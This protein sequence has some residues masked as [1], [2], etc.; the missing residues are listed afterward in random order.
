[1]LL[2]H[3]EYERLMQESSYQREKNKPGVQV[4]A[5][6]E[7]VSGEGEL[8]RAAKDSEECVEINAV[9]TVRVLGATWSEVP[10]TFT[11]TAPVAL[12]STSRWMLDDKEGCPRL[13]LYGPGTH[14]I[15]V[16]LLVPV[17]K[18]GGRSQLDF[19]PPEV[20]T[21]SLLIHLPG[22]QE[23]RGSLPV[24]TTYDQTN[25]YVRV[26]MGGSSA[27]HLE[28]IPS[29][30]GDDAKET[31]VFTQSHLAYAI[32]DGVIQITGSLGYSTLAGDLPEEVQFLIPPGGS[33]RRLEGASVRDWRIEDRQVTLVRGSG[34]R[35]SL[36]AEISLEVPFEPNAGVSQLPLLE[37]PGIT[38]HYGELALVGSPGLRLF[39]E[40]VENLEAI[41]TA[42]FFG[43]Q[44]DVTDRFIASYKFFSEPVSL[45]FQCLRDTRLMEAVV[46]TWAEFRKDAVHYERRIQVTQRGGETPRITL[47]LPVEEE[48]SSLI[49]GEGQQVDFEITQVSREQRILVEF[50]RP[51]TAGQHLTYVLQ[52]TLCPK[53]YHGLGTE[54]LAVL[55]ES[56]GIEEA[57][58]VSGTLAVGATDFLRLTDLEWR[59]MEPAPK[60]PQ[61]PSTLQS[62]SFRDQGE[63]LVRVSRRP[64]E[65]SALVLLSLLPKEGFLSVHGEVRYLL[66]GSGRKEFQLAFPKGLGPNFFPETERISERTMTQ[67]ETDDIWKLTLQNEVEGEFEV[68]FHGEIPMNGEVSVPEVWVPDARRERGYLI[69]EANAETEIDFESEGLSSLDPTGESFPRM[70]SYSPSHRLIAAFQYFVHP[71]SLKLKATRHT[72][73]PVLSAMADQLILTTVVTKDGLA[74]SQAVYSLRGVRVPFLS[75]NLP[76]DSELWTVRVGGVPVK[77]MR[78]EEGS[79]QIPLGDSLKR[80]MAERVGLVYETRMDPLGKAGSFDVLGPRLSGSVP[81][82]E[83]L[84]QLYLPEEYV[85]SVIS[86]DLTEQQ[87]SI[88]DPLILS[89]VQGGIEFF[90]KPFTSSFLAGRGD[91]RALSP[92]GTVETLGRV[93]YLE[94]GRRRVVASPP[95]VPQLGDKMTTAGRVQV[96]SELRG[97]PY[98]LPNIKAEELEA[99]RERNTASDRGQ[100]SDAGDF[101]L[102]LDD[103]TSD[104]NGR[105]QAMLGEVL[106]ESPEPAVMERP[107]IIN[108]F[109]AYIAPETIPQQAV[110][111][112]KPVDAIHVGTTTRAAGLIPLN[113]NLDPQ[114]VEYVFRDLRAGERISMG[115]RRV[116]SQSTRDL[117]SVLCAGLLFF[118]VVREGRLI[119]RSIWAAFFLTVAPLVLGNDWTDFFNRLLVGVVFGVCLALVARFRNRWLPKVGQMA[120]LLL[121]LAVAPAITEA[122]T[123][124]IP[125]NPEHPES[126]TAEERYWLPYDEFTDLWKAAKAHLQEP[127][128]AVGPVKYTLDHADYTLWVGEASATLRAVY[129]I[130][131]AA[132]DWITIPFPLDGAQVESARLDGQPALFLFEQSGYRLHLEERGPHLFEV[133]LL[134]PSKP[135]S[136]SGS[137]LQAIPQVSL[138][139]VKV[140]LPKVELDASIHP[141]TG[142]TIVRSEGGRKEVLAAIGKTASLSVKWHPEASRDRPPVPVK[143]GVRIRHSVVGNVENWKG[144]VEL[145]FHGET[146]SEFLLQ[147]DPSLSITSVQA[148]N[149]AGW[150]VVER[151]GKR[152]IQVQLLEEVSDTANL[153]L[154]AERVIDATRREVPLI[155]LPGVRETSFQVT[156]LS[157]P[158]ID[159]RVD[160]NGFRRGETVAEET[161]GMHAVGTFDSASHAATLRYEILERPQEIAWRLDYLFQVS[162]RKI[163]ETVLANFDVKKRP[164]FRMSLATPEGYRCELIE[165]Q[166]IKDWWQETGTSPGEGRVQVAFRSGLL[167]SSTMIVH[168]VSLFPDTLNTLS[169]APVRFLPEGEDSQAKIEGTVVVASHISVTPHAIEETGLVSTTLCDDKTPPGQCQVGGM[170]VVSPPLEK[171]LAYRFEKPSFSAKFSLDRTPP[172]YGVVWVTL[173]EA[174]E[175]WIAYSTHLQLKI[176]QGSLRTWD[177]LAPA[178]LGEIEVKGDLVREVSSQIEGES[179]RYK[180][181]MDSDLFSESSIIL[182]FEV[183]VLGPSSVPH[184][185]FPGAER[186]NGYLLTANDSSYELKAQSKGALERARQSDIPFLPRETGILD[187]FKIFRDEW[188]LELDLVRTVSADT[189][190][191]LIDWVDMETLIR[192]DGTILTVAS[193]RISNKS[194]QFLPIH[195]PPGADLL[196]LIVAGEASGANST[197]RD[198]ENILLV[199][200]IKTA[201]GQLSFVIEVVY[202]HKHGGPL[203]RLNS[204]AFEGPRILDIPVAQTLWTLFVPDDYEPYWLTGNMEETTQTLREYS[205]L[206]S[207]E[208]ERQQLKTL[209]VG[210]YDVSTRRRALENYEKA[211]AQVQ[212]QQNTLQGRDTSREIQAN[213]RLRGKAGGVQQELGKASQM[214]SSN[215]LSGE[216]ERFHEKV[217]SLQREISEKEAVETTNARSGVSA[218]N[219]QERSWFSNM[220]PQPTPSPQAP[221]EGVDYQQISSNTYFFGSQLSPSKKGIPQARGDVSRYLNLSQSDQQQNLSESQIMSSNSAI[222]RELDLRREETSFDDKGSWRKQRIVGN[223]AMQRELSKVEVQAL[224]S[225]PETSKVAEQ[226]GGTTAGSVGDQPRRE[227]STQGQIKDHPSAA[228]AYS[229]PIRV[230]REG[231]PITFRKL[232]ADARVEFYALDRKVNETALRMVEV[233]LAAVLLW[234]AMT[235]LS[236]PAVKSHLRRRWREYAA[237]PGVLCLPFAP[238][239]GMGMLVA[240]LVL[241]FGRVWRNSLAS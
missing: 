143:A 79:V 195:L 174:H 187:S 219:G 69:V 221:Q 231:K 37:V 103:H 154:T 104:G 150:S 139:T 159:L 131:H 145:L 214:I 26:A 230:P 192:R 178:S 56:V 46:D 128:Q 9:Y 232:H 110:P 107:K 67:S 225:I 172:R 59:E 100:F 60:P 146:R 12:E 217:A 222:V 92:S 86:S 47:N 160:S 133:E 229:I 121:L 126:A 241:R 211:S 227:G 84:W 65:T 62:F 188:N 82:A 80:D 220:L 233:A 238:V 209:V 93:G 132:E 142:G 199:P 194:L 29:K 102:D 173:A 208:E 91:V 16:R 117:L 234:V 165:G 44:I 22:R 54:G 163:E 213:R 36:D 3:D 151:G 78:G 77:P 180:I 179:R 123:V 89:A 155:S 197:V 166:D 108:K 223:G 30:S 109:A 50:P 73:A 53:D 75:A 153:Q 206:T 169:I 55:I 31:A 127:D 228:G 161:P 157:A 185:S 95:S 182:S 13:F 88:P 237:L 15:S 201:P 118:L 184:L 57:S 7:S 164:L 18:E 83:T 122:S 105:P 215:I 147:A 138:S 61:R 99:V 112:A 87:G 158:W 70:N 196:S 175:T 10:F 52:T 85:Y 119:R 204:L 186:S 120:S 189:L 210:D 17:R 167:G 74:R 45:S 25:T 106:K 190:D 176:L 114:G 129:H 135:G 111:A 28:W 191:A 203:K 124:Y 8:L 94:G 39:V 218:V 141:V 212:E 181:Q 4:G 58:K 136:H 149:L 48:F 240:W 14:K 170:L 40:T 21:G 202:E 66:E 171:K 1:V 41:D 81:V 64:A 177:F 27:F 33:L 49:D 42:I 72:P 148:P 71:F 20:P 68:R 90:A 226:R 235:I 140:I 207:L 168:L 200:L 205:K 5:A 198:G 6:Y 97:S 183:P 19:V 23:V 115:F 137:V 144:S 101:V 193:I 116:E 51:L 152:D 162:S 236:W 11:G 2:S 113:I 239:L 156:L 224:Q 32:L 216:G 43:R 134:Y 63:L 38:R 24:H 125:Y 98:F 76:K 96:P 35:S 130:T 34:K